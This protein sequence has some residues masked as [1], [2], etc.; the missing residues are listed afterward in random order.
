MLTNDLSCGHYMIF[1]TS[2]DVLMGEVLAI[3]D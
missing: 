2:D 1:K 3:S